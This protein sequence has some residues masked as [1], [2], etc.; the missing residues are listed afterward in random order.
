LSYIFK[1]TLSVLSRRKRSFFLT[2]LAI[3]LGISLVVQTEILTDTIERNYKEIALEAYGNGDMIVY[4]YNEVYFD[5]LVFDILVQEFGSE[6]Q[7][8]VPRIA[9]GTTVYYPEKGQFEQFVRL[10]TIA[11][12]FNKNFWGRVVSNSTGSDIDVASLELHEVVISSELADALG[13]NKGANLTI[14]LFDENSN[15]IPLNVTVKEIFNNEGYG[16]VGSAIDFRRILMSHQSLQSYIESNF[17]TP[18]S[19]NRPI[20]SILIGI[21]DHQQEPFL[22]REQTD[23]ARIQVENVLDQYYPIFGYESE[24]DPLGVWTFREDDREGLEQGVASIGNILNLFGSVVIIAGLLLI[25]NVQLL[26]MEERKQQIGILRAVGAKKREILISY[27]I[28]TV[29]LGVLGGILGLFL[30]GGLSIIMN[31]ITRD[32]LSTAEVSRS[33][34]DIVVNSETLFTSVFYA[35]LLSLMTGMVPA[36]RARG[37]SIV[38][39]VRG[40]KSDFKN[41][42][43]EK[44]SLWPLIIGGLFLF[45]GIFMLFNLIQQG[46]PFYSSKGYR[47]IENEAPD[48]L[49]ALMLVALGLIFASFRFPSKTRILVTIGGL[50][51]IGIT[52]FG[53]QAV[54][55]WF[56]EGNSGNQIVMVGLICAVIG[57][58]T[59]V[60]ANLEII[61]AI[62][63]KMFSFTK[64]TRAAGLVSTR[65]INSRKSRAVLTFATFAVILSLNF[66]LG[67]YVETQNIGYKD[68]MEDNFTNVQ[69]VVES[70]TP[71]NLTSLDYPQILQDNFN[72]I[73]HITPLATAY[74]FGYYYENEVN[75]TVPPPL[76]FYTKRIYIDFETFREDE[77]NTKYPFIFDSLVPYYSQLS[78]FERIKNKEAARNEAIAFWNDFLND[79]KLHRE[80]LQ[81]TS[82]DDP[83]GLPMFIGSFLE[84]YY[85]KYDIGEIVALPT[86]DGN[87]IEMIYA[88]SLSYFPSFNLYE[89]YNRIG[90]LISSEYANQLE[91][92]NYGYK[93][94]MIETG[95][96]DADENKALCK[97]IEEFSNAPIASDSNTLLSITNG[98]MYGITAH[99]IWDVISSDLE[100]NARALF[101]IQVFISTGLII[102]VVGLLVVSRRSVTE[103]KREIGMFRSLGFSKVSVS[104]A[105]LLEL[106]LLGGL[107][108][109]VGFLT[110]NYIAWVL[111]DLQGYTLLIPWGQVSFFGFIILGSVFIAAL[112]P[113]YLAA[114]IPPSEALRYNG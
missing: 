71:M 21:K 68:S 9:F 39:I 100:E 16:K 78:A 47:N 92:F 106:V 108:F 63:R 37:I 70:Q 86:L 12:E 95:T 107:G 48:N 22:G 36:L 51:M 59:V 105:V 34:F 91:H 75:E 4:S 77:E 90:I 11:P 88:G 7:G 28:E 76:R 41:P 81:P 87:F 113:G 101:M 79:T 65:Y 19:I 80:T 42:Y 82:P 89:N 25:V 67:S 57:A 5:Q 99:H 15:S 26:N 58:T 46:T 20:T 66:M 6:F 24:E 2:S 18:N 83:Q 112:I 110:G 30:G 85:Y 72:E 35:I 1:Y 32:I 3:A 111:A 94:F 13:A 61:T 60:G 104:L 93:E 98:I 40:V 45:F 54:L 62:M 33:A 10:E 84:Y 31:E 103:R 52:V 74:G 29:L 96:F 49:F 8:I 53:F 73:Q 64:T 38:E 55:Y 50:I 14:N 102:G 56:E 43:N 17:N 44:K 69:I 109:F 23:Q 27:S 97:K 114:R